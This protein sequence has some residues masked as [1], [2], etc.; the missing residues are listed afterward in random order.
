MAFLYEKIDVLREYGSSISLPAYVSEN[1]NQDFE[2]RPYQKMAYEN[3]ITY[4]E[5]ANCPKPT[6]VLYHMATGSGKTLIMA[7]LMLYLYKKGYRNFLFFVN[8]SNIV[9]KTKNNFCN[10]ASSKYLFAENILIDGENVRINQVDNF[11]Y[12]EKDAINICFTTTQGLHMDM[13]MA[14]ENG[15]SFDDFEARK[16]VLISD[17]AHHLNVETKKKISADEESNYRS[18]EQT[19]KNIFGRNSGN[20]LL[21]FTATC[22]IAN[23]AIRA[24]YENKIIFD[25]TLAKFYWDRY[26]KDIVTLRSDLTIMER[27]LQALVLSQYRLKVFQDYRLAIKPVVLFKAAKIA[28]SKDF[29]NDFIDMVKKLSGV[30]LQ[31]LSNTANNEVMQ[32]AFQ[33]F[34]NNGITMDVLAAELRDDFAEAHCVSV[35]DDKDATQKQILLNSLEDADNPYRA[36]FEVKKLDEGWDVLNLFDIVRLYETRQSGR[37]KL[38]PA[39]IA[40]AQLIGR[41][42]RYCPFQVEEE[43]PKFQR[44]YDDDVKCELRVCETLYYHCQNDHRYVAELKNALREIGLD[45]DKIVQKEYVL[46][47]DFKKDEIYTNGIVFINEREVK[48]RKDVKGLNPTVRDDIYRY[49]VSAGASGMDIVMDETAKPIDE[50]IELKTAHMTIKEIADINYAIVNKALMRYPIFKFNT[51]K[52][53]FPNIDST[54]QFI[55]D[56]EYLGA[57]RI[58]IQSKEK[59]PTMET[60]YHA[61]YYVLGKIATSI[62]EI[63]ETYLGTRRFQPKRVRDIFRNKTVNYTDPHDGGAGISQ[64]D[65]SVRKE[66]RIDLADKEWFAY[67][68]NYGTSEEKAFVSYFSSYV[69]ELKKVYSKVYLLRNE[70]EFH[71][72]SF[73]DGERFEPDY[74]LLLQKQK[75]DGFEQLQIFIEPKGS[76]LLEKDAWKEKFLLQLKENAEP[77]KIFKDDNDYRIWGFHFFNQENRMQDFDI[78]MMGV[79][80]GV[81]KHILAYADAIENNNV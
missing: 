28:D 7:G 17:E 23:P 49:Q 44:K 27:A 70:R 31:N 52:S 79:V 62:S 63:E 36:I 60:M 15:M 78:D 68:D 69:D 56:K 77:V 58:D 8:L 73:E 40:E 59:Q 14:K 76:Q 66:W 20:V 51:L 5:G 46:K 9:E 4:F 67:M 81:G 61:V 54:R 16:V 29:M 41:G 30:E 72:Y 3:F 64:K 24:A 47:D 71:I 6:Q 12:A 48:S 42:A 1:L 55:T 75:T 80:K 19:V 50:K 22:D 32:K 10:P 25:Y 45:T 13:W 33:Y 21:E 38:S 43:Q 2:L 74:V 18:W 53:Y 37:A 34:M 57:V 11:Q 65:D 35:N 26:S 39:T